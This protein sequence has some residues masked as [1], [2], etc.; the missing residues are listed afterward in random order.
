MRERLTFIKPQAMGG[1]RSE[2]RESL[3]ALKKS[4]LLLAQVFG[5]LAV[6]ISV[7]WDFSSKQ[8]ALMLIQKQLQQI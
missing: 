8:V 5:I 6:S 1:S 7:L 4:P 3:I 2:D